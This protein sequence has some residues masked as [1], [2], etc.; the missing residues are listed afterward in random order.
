ML[1]VAHVSS[2]V[3]RFCSYMLEIAEYDGCRSCFLHVAHGLDRIACFFTHVRA[4]LHNVYLF[5]YSC[6]H[7]LAVALYFL[8]LELNLSSQAPPPVHSL[9]MSVE[10][11]G[12]DESLLDGFKDLREGDPA[13]KD[14]TPNK[15]KRWCAEDCIGCWSE[16]AHQNQQVPM[17]CLP[18]LVLCR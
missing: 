6:T 7:S 3:E 11:D 9:L 14:S 1:L 2:W 5:V 13:D 15:K 8:T 4:Y 12:I 17:P 16:E 10:D 18:A